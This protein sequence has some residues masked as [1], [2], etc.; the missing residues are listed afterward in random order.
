M[1]RFS[2]PLRGSGLKPKTTLPP[3]LGLLFISKDTGTLSGDARLGWLSSSG[4]LHIRG[5]E[6]GVPSPGLVGSL[7]LCTPPESSNLWTP[8]LMTGGNRE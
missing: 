4:A 8:L 5:F 1:V 2:P 7:E 6:T 3:F